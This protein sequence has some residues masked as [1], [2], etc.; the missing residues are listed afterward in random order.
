VLRVAS[1]APFAAGDVSVRICANAA[2]RVSQ[3]EPTVVLQ[4]CADL[5]VRAVAMATPALP[6]PED[7][8]LACVI[9]RAGQLDALLCTLSTTSQ[10]APVDDGAGGPL[11]TVPAGALNPLAPGAALRWTLARGSPLAGIAALNSTTG[12][13][14][15]TVDA[16][17]SPATFLIA[18]TA[19]DGRINVTDGYNQTSAIDIVL[20]VANSG[21]APTLN[22]TAS[23]LTA[24]AVT[25]ST[26]TARGA[27]FALPLSVL[28]FDDPGRTYAYFL[29][30]TKATGVFSV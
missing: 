8:A 2:G 5:L 23:S 4:S 30:D 28:D 9:P 18:G 22:V 25:L 21:S 7:V 10:P 3:K 19:Y 29:T 27:T 14:R 13:L 1:T 11:A 16:A 12:E 6:T 15:L 20:V 24:P 26:T 17:S